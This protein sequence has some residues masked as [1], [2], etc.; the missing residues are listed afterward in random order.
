[1]SCLLHII[2]IGS[3]ILRGDYIYTMFIA[4]SMDGNNQT[5]PIAFGL[6]M[7]NNVFPDSYHRY[8]SKSMSCI[9]AQ[10][11]VE[12]NIGTF[13]LYEIQLIYYVLSDIGHVKWATTYFPNIRWNEIKIHIPKFMLVL[14]I[15]QCNVLIIMFTESIHD[16]IQRCF[17]ERGLMG[18]RLT[19]VLSR[20]QKWFVMM[21]MQGIMFIGLL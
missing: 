9:C 7:T 1:M 8:T 20:M 11:L 17:D 21:I 14:S 19:S 2:F 13:V 3:V 15:N 6:G 16:Y 12:Q 5:L 10:E 4:V 18:G